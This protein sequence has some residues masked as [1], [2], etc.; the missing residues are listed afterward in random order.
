[1]AELQLFTYARQHPQG[2]E[3]STAGDR[4]F[5]AL[6]ACLEDGRTI[7]EAYQLDVKGYRQISDDWRVWKG[8]P[9]LIKMH[10]QDTWRAYKGLWQMWA[11]ENPHLLELLRQAAVSRVLTDR[12]AYTEV[13]QARALAE[14]L[15]ESAS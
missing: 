5:S 1:V 9:P 14:I 11:E 7:E 8:K 13:S 2:Y 12:F 15:N 10:P 3:C 4:R 6:F